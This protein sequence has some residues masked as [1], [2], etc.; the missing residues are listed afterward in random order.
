[1]FGPETKFPAN[2]IISIP[3][4]RRI[5]DIG[6]STRI[7][8]TSSSGLPIA[9]VIAKARKGTPSIVAIIS[10]ECARSIGSRNTRG[11]SAAVL[12][13]IEYA[14]PALARAIVL[15]RNRRALSYVVVI[16]VKPGMATITLQ[17]CFQNDQ[18]TESIR[19]LRI[20]RFHTGIFDRRIEAAEDLLE[21]VVIAFAV[22]AGEIG[23][24]ARA[25]LQQRG[26]FDNYLV[27]RVP[28]ADPQLIGPLLIPGDTRLAPV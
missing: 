19:E 15:T 25:F 12:A 10:A 1:M 4:D 14:T 22:S 9:M 11:R 24:R 5:G 13:R 28:V 8:I 2:A 26:I 21:R 27:A 23:V 3:T 20:L 17:L 6:S 16:D 18:L 7:P